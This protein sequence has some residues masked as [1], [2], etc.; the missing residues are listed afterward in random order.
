MSYDKFLG[1]FRR[2]VSDI[3][4]YSGGNPSC[5][6]GAAYGLIGNIKGEKFWL[7]KINKRLHRS[8]LPRQFVGIVTRDGPNISIS[9]RF[10]IV[11]DT[12]LMIY[13]LFFSFVL[14]CIVSF[15]AS[16]ELSAAIYLFVLCCI[17]FGG[18]EIT[19]RVHREEDRAVIAYLENLRDE[20]ANKA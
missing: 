17:F 6:S 2:D 10:K 15:I 4:N 1:R 3:S 12:R 5:S 9:G 16:S 20:Y 14:C 18:N 19:K 8:A 7:Q 13:F 11:D